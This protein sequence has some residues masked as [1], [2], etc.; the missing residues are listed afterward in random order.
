[1]FKR[2]DIITVDRPRK[3]IKS[4]QEVEFAIWVPDSWGFVS[5]ATLLA[6][7]HGDLE[8]KGYKMDFTQKED[9][10]ISK[11]TVKVSF[12]D[13]G[14]HYFYFEIFLNGEKT[15]LKYDYQTKQPTTNGGDLWKVTV[16]DKQ[17]ETP[18]WAKGK[19][20]YHIFVDRF[21]KSENY[22]TPAMPGRMQLYWGEIP[23]WKPNADGEIKNEEFF[24]G[25]LLGVEEKLDYFND[26]GVEILYL[27]PICRSQSNHRYDTSDY[28]E[29]D[30]YL[31]N[32]ETIKTLCKQA[33]K[34]G[35][36]VILDGVFNHTGND[37]VYFNEFSHFNT[38]GAY[39]S[40]DSNYYDMYSKNE[41]GQFSYWW[42]FKNLPKCDGKSQMWIDF[43]CGVEGVIDQWFEWGIDGVRLD[44]A[45]ELTDEFIE[46]IRIAVHRNKKD[47][48][49][50]GEVW[51]HAIEKEIYGRKRQYLLGKGLDSV[52]N[53]PF[54][55]AI[56]KYIRFGDVECFRETITSILDEY[57]P[58]AISTLMTSLSTHDI[59]RAMTTLAGEGI[60][61]FA[62]QWVWDVTKNRDW[63]YEHDSLGDNYNLAKTRFK[64]ATI[65]QYFLPGNPCIFYGDE[66]GL[67]GYKDPFNRKCYPWGH[68]DNELLEFFKQ[69]G[70]LKK[71]VTEIYKLDFK[72]IY[73][74]N[75][76]LIFERT[77]NTKSILIAVNRT[78]KQIHIQIPEMYKLKGKK[79][80]DINASFEKLNSYGAI[81][82]MA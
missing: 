38:I 26:L 1:M 61:N 37:S 9:E 64:L 33:H 36:N 23:T 74:T 69:I 29:V 39:Q 16:Y 22:V 78:D 76:V 2:T 24:M 75:D 4:E 10:K 59:T 67:H 8:Q 65:I 20:I 70:E 31:G 15:I 13:V 62:Y 68:E 44:V 42:G 80:F 49:I 7:K 5:K 50:V 48:F 34:R 57:P 56:L 47:G 79:V 12:E 35:I 54:S 66:V 41:N 63:Q 77:D 81:I 52:M 45:D 21:S 51:D 3:A 32:K 28:E 71:S 18:T 25:N 60:N 27:S 6:C 73:I 30:P 82:I 14:I 19:L 17:F 53:Y 72:I 40:K 43:I 55:N 11:F 58:C 46:R